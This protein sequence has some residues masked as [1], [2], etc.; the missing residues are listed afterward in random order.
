[1][2]SRE[3][4]GVEELSRTALGKRGETLVEKLLKLK[5]NRR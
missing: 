3:A 5:L 2:P 1:M 4:A